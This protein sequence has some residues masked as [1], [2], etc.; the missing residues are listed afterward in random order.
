MAGNI[1]DEIKNLIRAQYPILY[2]E[3][4]EED[5]AERILEAIALDLGL[6]FYSWT[7]PG[8]LWK[9][10][11]LVEGDLDPLAVLQF[12]NERDTN[13]LF[14]LKDYHF[15]INEPE[16]KRALRNI[17][18][19]NDIYTPIVITAPVLQLPVE[20]EKKITVLELP[21]PDADEIAEL[22]DGA[23]EQ[24]RAW[25]PDAEL[26]DEVGR[27]ALIKAG[28]GLTE[29]E[30]ENILAKSWTKY[31]RLDVKV[32]L[33][34]KK[35]TIKKSGILEYYE[36][37]EEFSNVGGMDQLKEWL[38][39]RGNAFSEKAERFGLPQPKGVL[40]TGIPGCGKSLI[41]KAVAGFWNMPLL[42]LD[43]GSIFSGLVGSSEENI[44]KALRVAEAV[45]P[46]VLFLDEI[47]KGL[48]GSESS[49]RTDG[50]TSSRV[51]G[52]LLSWLQDKTKPVFVI[53]TA[54]DISKLPPELLRP[55]RFDERFFVDLPT[56]SEREE[57]LAIHLRKR[58]RDPEKFDLKHLA[59]ISADYSGAELE[60]A[61]ISAMYNVFTERPDEDITTEDVAEAIRNTIPLSVTKG[62]DLDRLR[63]WATTNAIF[64]SS[65]SEQRI[66]GTS[67]VAVTDRSKTRGKRDRLRLI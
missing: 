5:R 53:A 66:K 31:Q 67:G 34:E 64:A 7:F 48:S 8:G 36:N 29:Q 13:S 33:E 58:N 35:Q 16:I 41:A 40:L 25:K 59:E 18:S 47:E 39:R 2:I 54:N 6:D 55:G 50:G 26:P 15:A 1:Y 32:M 19:T 63:Q 37:L 46:V 24:L 57:I 60:Q 9:Q 38:H 21:L 45:A 62:R 42:K 14:M 56:A 12:I 23:I 10:Q 30:L 44:R 65:E 22:I 3:T 11:E 43:M 51:F 61:I 20:L 17:K 28:Q 4:H 49:G 52:Y 27:E